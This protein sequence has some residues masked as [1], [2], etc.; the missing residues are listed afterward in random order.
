MRHKKDGWDRFCIVMIWDWFDLIWFDWCVSFLFIAFFLWLFLCCFLSYSFYYF[1]FQLNIHI[2]PVSCFSQTNLL[3]VLF[4]IE[5]IFF[6]EATFALISNPFPCGRVGGIIFF[7]R[8]LFFLF[9]LE[10]FDLA[11]KN[12]NV[13]QRLH[14]DP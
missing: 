9:D 8:F 3:I 4:S 13:S 2:R 1:I 5:I 11:K 6:I 14:Y 12:F 10:F 7:V